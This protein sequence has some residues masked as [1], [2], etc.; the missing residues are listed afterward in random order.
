M[1][2]CKDCNTEKSLSEFYV[3][4]NGIHRTICKKCYRQRQV[5]SKAYEPHGFNYFAFSSLIG[6]EYNFHKGSYG[7]RD[8]SEAGDVQEE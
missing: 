8:W 7:H 4:G 6:N 2:E 3:Y 5:K 1:K